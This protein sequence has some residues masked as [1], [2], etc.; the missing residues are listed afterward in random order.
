MFWF[1][2]VGLFG[3]GGVVI[4]LGFVVRSWGVL[5]GL[6]LCIG[7]TGASVLCERL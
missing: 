4:G 2:R 5:G 3:L 6:L 7:L 1:V